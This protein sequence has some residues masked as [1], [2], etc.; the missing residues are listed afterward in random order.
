MKFLTNFF[1]NL[2]KSNPPDAG[3]LPEKKISSLASISTPTGTKVNKTVLFGVLFIIVIC[4]TYS[5]YSATEKPKSKKTEDPLAKSQKG[6]QSNPFDNLPNSYDDKNK[7]TDP[8][9]FPLANQSKIP[10]PTAP[11]VPPTPP[12][13][14]REQQAA[15]SAKLQAHQRA[16]QEEDMAMKSKINIVDRKKAQEVRASQPEAGSPANPDTDPNRQSDKINF[17]NNSK[18][19]NLIN[20]QVIV[21]SLSK[22]LVQ[23]G[24]N[25][26]CILLTGINTDLPGNIVA[27]VSENVYDTATGNYLLIPQGS[28]LIGRYDSKVTYGQYRVLLVWQRLM[29]PN[30]KSILLENMQGSDVSGYS[31][32]RDK[33]DNHSPDLIRGI[34]LSSI[35]SATAL[36]ATAPT[37]NQ[38]NQYGAAAGQGAAQAIL[39][40]G[41]QITKKNLDRQPTLNIRQG[42]QFMVMVHQDLILEPFNN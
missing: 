36:A 35:L 30:G 42:H 16:A 21:P 33:V 13:L 20:A 38:N 2:K 3:N 11:P 14:T 12:Q 41:G 10:I 25:I 24:S 18:L 7:S 40:V 23:A 8:H 28:K 34:I 26:P 19:P 17:M 31:G 32:L 22:Y 5:L 9:K 6:K 1:K 27:Q 37:G 15:L 39:D 4:I 29:L